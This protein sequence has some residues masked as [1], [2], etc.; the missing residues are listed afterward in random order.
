MTT[1]NRTKVL[2][3]IKRYC[4]PSKHYYRWTSYALKEVFERLAGC[5]INHADFKLLMLE[6]GFTPTKKSVK[7]GNHRYKLDILQCPEISIYYWGKGSEPYK[8]G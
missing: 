4:I 6:A 5:Y 8:Y 1:E 7:D 3:L 2:E